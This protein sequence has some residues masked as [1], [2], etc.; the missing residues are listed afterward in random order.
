MDYTAYLADAIQMVEAW[1]VPE[2]DFADAVNQ[3][4]KLMAGQGLEPSDD[5][6][7][8]YPHQ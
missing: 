2:E 5:I 7:I 1:E 4:M 6:T 3:Q 8:P